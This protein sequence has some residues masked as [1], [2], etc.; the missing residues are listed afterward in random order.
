MGLFHNVCVPLLHIQAV[1]GTQFLLHKRAGNLN[2][3]FLLLSNLY[4]QYRNE[5]Q[6]CFLCSEASILLTLIPN[7]SM[8]LFVDSDHLYLYY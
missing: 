6:I 8:D 3:H 2:E 7:S 1:V 5:Y 4:W